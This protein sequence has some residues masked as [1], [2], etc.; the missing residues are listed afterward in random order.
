MAP[1]FKAKRHAVSMT[2]KDTLLTGLDYQNS[3]S[4]EGG[5]PIVMPPL[6]D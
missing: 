5:I 4:S 1:P 2:H 6:T 3:G